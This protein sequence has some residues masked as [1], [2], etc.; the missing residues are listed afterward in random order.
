MTPVTMLSTKVRN[1]DRSIGAI[2]I[3]SPIRRLAGRMFDWA[4][5]RQITAFA[6]ENGIGTHLDGARLFIA[7]A[8]TG[9][10]PAEYAALFDT[11]YVSL[12]KGLGGLAGAAAGALA[13]VLTAGKEVKIPAESVLKF[14]LDEPVQLQ[15]ATP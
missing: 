6:R 11:V 14:K 1:A 2:L 5:A 12:Y 8:Y 3:E 7:S 15:P 9:I 13:Q 4:E 10:T